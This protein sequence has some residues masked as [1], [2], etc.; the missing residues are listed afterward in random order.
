MKRGRPRNRHMAYQPVAVE[1]IP[2]LRSWE[3]EYQEFWKI[4]LDRCINGYKPHGHD[5][6][7]GRYYF[8]L[9]FIKFPTAF[10]GSTRKVMDFP[11]YR[12][13]DHE[14]FC[15]VEDAKKAGKGLMVLKARRKGMSMNNV[16]GICI[17]EM[18]I[19]KDVNIGVGCFLEDTVEE[20]RRKFENLYSEMPEYFVQNR[21]SDNKD[22]ILFGKKM[23][24]GILKGSKNMMYF[25][26]FYNNSGAFRGF[27]LDFLLF[28]EAGENMNLLNS[29]LVSEECFREGGYQFGTP[30]IF[31][32][33][34]QINNGLKDLEELWHNHDKYNMDRL[35]ISAEKAYYPFFDIRTGKSDIIGASEDILGKR[36]QKKALQ[37]K[38]AYFTY[39]QEM[40]M[41]DTDCFLAG[42]SGVFNLELIHDQLE[43]LLTNKREE[44]RVIRGKLEWDKNAEGDVLTHSVSWIPERHGKMKMLL[45]PLEENPYIDV[46]GVDPYVK[47][48]S[49]TSDSLGSLHIFRGAVDHISEDEL[50]VFEY[51][52]RPKAGKEEFY[53]NCAK[54][55]VFYDCQLLVEDTD[56]EFFKWFKT[57][58]FTRYLKRA[59]VVY[60]T[61]TSK[62]SNQYGYNISG[63]GRK[64][65]LI[66]TVNEYLNKCCHKIFYKELLKE[67]TI[68]GIKNTDR[69]MSFG[70][71]LIHS[72]DNSFLR[73]REIRKE[74]NESISFPVFQKKKRG[75]TG[76][77]VTDIFDML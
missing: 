21:I 43:F 47:D 36:K 34:N 77:K 44:G 60:K 22:E 13:I 27:S 1:G 24:D 55:A 66:D 64:V 59:P 62:A 38:R 18:T 58:G 70:M 6:I 7:P 74:N 4:Q 57:N 50:P 5:W 63:Q 45:P 30:I 10:G 14:Y 52:D 33:S 16:G 2:K 72:K 29:F 71:A 51:V 26:H 9:N 54:I 40:P 42:A 46:G 19:N 20:F 25:K 11:F 67:F 48:Q 3:R 68:F 56:E 32:T 35:F 17:Y 49:D 73:L 61:L 76:A 53:E 69:V 39:L 37:D 8:Y 65:K 31:G 15:A 41:K 12:D 23:P 28:E 75:I